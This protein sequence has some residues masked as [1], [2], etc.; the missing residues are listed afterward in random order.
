MNEIK[1]EGAACPI[2]T[3]CQRWERRPSRETRLFA[4]APFRRDACDFYQPADR[5]PLDRT[6]EPL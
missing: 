6:T 3:T 4:A 5:I 2:K 1:C